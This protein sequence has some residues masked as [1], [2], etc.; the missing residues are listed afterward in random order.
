MSLNFDDK[1]I[2]AMLLEV[3]KHHAVNPSSSL[4]SEKFFRELLLK[5]VGK[6][7]ARNISPW[8]SENIAKHFIALGER[9]R[10]L[11]D[12]EW[13]FFNNQPMV[14]SGQIDW[15]VK[16]NELATKIFHDD[17]SFYLFIAQ[18]IKPVIVM[19]QK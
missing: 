13:P 6:F 17:T 8:L 3:C 12:A 14:F 2:Y 15:H 18:K 1:Q 10:W 7:D 4:E 5:F 11:Q 9:P 16:D 19:Q